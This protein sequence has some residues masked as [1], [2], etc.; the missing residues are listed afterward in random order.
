M[1]VLPAQKRRWREVQRQISKCCVAANR[2]GERAALSC[3]SRAAFYEVLANQTAEQLQAVR[4]RRPAVLLALAN[5]KLELP[6]GWEAD[7]PPR[8]DMCSRC[9][10]LLEEVSGQCGRG[11][12]G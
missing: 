5:F 12:S 3:Q 11:K 10:G 9:A 2:V 7:P 6:R 4:G 1:Y 8:L